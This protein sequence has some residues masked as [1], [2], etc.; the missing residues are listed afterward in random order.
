ML[1]EQFVITIQALIN[2]RNIYQLT[3]HW[4]DC[5]RSINIQLNLIPADNNLRIHAVQLL[6]MPGTHPESLIW[7]FGR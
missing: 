1:P 4:I 7:G 5:I 2:K 3:I 6:K